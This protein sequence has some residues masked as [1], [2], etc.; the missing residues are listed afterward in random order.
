MK[1]QVKGHHYKKEKK[2]KNIIFSLSFEYLRGVAK[3]GNCAYVLSHADQ[4]QTM[5]KRRSRG[6][7][8]RVQIAL[9]GRWREEG[10]RFAFAGGG[11]LEG[12]RDGSEHREAVVGSE[13]SAA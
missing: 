13:H 4:P 12:V 9:S 10:F 3:C 11:S 1:G 2:E 6:N 7:A 5:M 8:E